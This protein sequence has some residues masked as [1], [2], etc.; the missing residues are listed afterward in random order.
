MES[1]YEDGK[2]KFL[3]EF[4]PGLKKKLF[5]TYYPNGNIKTRYREHVGTTYYEPDGTIK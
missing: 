4:G 1:F 5:K 3:A 2:P